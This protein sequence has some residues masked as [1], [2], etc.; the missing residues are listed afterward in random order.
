MVALVGSGDPRGDISVTVNISNVKIGHLKKHWSF[1][2][3]GVNVTPN[4]QLNYKHFPRIAPVGKP[5]LIL[6]T[7]TFTCAV[8]MPRTFRSQRRWVVKQRKQE[9]RLVE[10]NF[11]KSI[12]LR[13]ILILTNFSRRKPSVRSLLYCFR[14]NKKKILKILFRKPCRRMT[15]CRV[16]RDG[17][18]KG[19]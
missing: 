16:E 1:V 2:I 12:S 8:K 7:P 9:S 3:K 10:A 19:V 5:I 15:R 11:L 13:S 6:T 14:I 17:C 4:F 18:M